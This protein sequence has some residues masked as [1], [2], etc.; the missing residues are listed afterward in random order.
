MQEEKE[1]FAKEKESILREMGQRRGIEERAK[2]QE[3]EIGRLQEVVL[4]LKNDL[5]AVT[6]PKEPPPPSPPTPPT[7]S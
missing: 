4:T 6:A 1:G 7:S 5:A 2:E 3:R